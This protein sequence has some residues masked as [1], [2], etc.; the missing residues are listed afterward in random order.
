MSSIFSLNNVS[1]IRVF[2]YTCSHVLYHD[3]GN[4]AWIHVGHAHRE[5]LKRWSRSWLNAC[6]G[7]RMQE[8]GRPSCSLP[9]SPCLPGEAVMRFSH[10]L[11]S[12]DEVGRLQAPPSGYSSR[13]K[14]PWARAGPQQRESYHASCSGLSTSVWVSPWEGASGTWHLWYLLMLV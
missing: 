11:P 13:I 10:L 4:L 14:S 2:T 12:S 1:C 6:D 5:G 7:S 3:R 9:I 8:H